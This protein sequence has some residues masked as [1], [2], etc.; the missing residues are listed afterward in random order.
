MFQLIERTMSIELEDDLS[1]SLHDGI[2]LCRLANL[3]RPHS[4]AHI[5]EP[6]SDVVS[7]GIP[8]CVKTMK[9]MKF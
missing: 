7:F 8:E 4:V 1:S 9:V 3:V 6:E 5:S 2:I